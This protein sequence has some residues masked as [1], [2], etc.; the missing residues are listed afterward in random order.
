MGRKR[1]RIKCSPD[2]LG[3]LF[4]RAAQND[5]AA[6]IEKTYEFQADD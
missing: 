2:K 3:N 5:S 6:E 1:F 4:A